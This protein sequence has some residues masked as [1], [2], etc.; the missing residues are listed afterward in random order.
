[1]TI[2]CYIINRESRLD[3]KHN[4]ITIFN[5]LNENNPKLNLIFSDNVADKDLIPDLKTIPEIVEN[6]N[7][8]K[9]EVA[10]SIS[11]FNLWTF[12]DEEYK[13]I[14]ED[15]ILI[16]QDY[17]S[18]IEKYLK[19]LEKDKEWDIILLSRNCFGDDEKD[20][21]KV[22][23]KVNEDFYVPVKLGYGAHSYIVNKRCIE[24]IA[25]EIY[26]LKQTID[27]LFNEWHNKNKVKFYVSNI[28]LTVPMN[29]EDSDTSSK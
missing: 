17:N 7:L 12:K 27:V 20:C 14:K 4:I 25:I 11:H 16:L 8:S 13:I 28:N 10:A 1:M 19:Y 9:G 6:L 15:D 2:N 23:E 29:I 22:K 26:P 3:R 18:I 21:F 5:K 24:K